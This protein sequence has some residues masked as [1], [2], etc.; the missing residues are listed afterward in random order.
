[1]SEAEYIPD[2]RIR[3]VRVTGASMYTH[4]HVVCLDERR[5]APL[6][7]AFL[8]IVKELQGRGHDPVD[9]HRQ[10]QS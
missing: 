8:D 4:A 7:K 1:M 6:V 10:R 5:G 3:M 9:E 2:P